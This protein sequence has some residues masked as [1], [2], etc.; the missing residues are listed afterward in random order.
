MS[1]RISGIKAARAA[2]A[3]FPV[4]AREAINE[5]HE[6]TAEQI[7]RNAQGRV[8]KRSGFLARSISYSLDKRAGTAKVGIEKGLAFYGHF[9]EFGTIRMKAKPFL[10][11]AVE[12]ETPFHERRM[13]D[14]GSAIER[15]VSTF[16]SRFD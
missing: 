7:V 6:I 9:L 11:P 1:V 12:V 15:D 8:R 2:F 16:G 3:R 10:I 5:A 13:R 14:A 4:A